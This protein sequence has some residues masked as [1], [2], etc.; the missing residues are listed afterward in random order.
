MS[1]PVN[2]NVYFVFSKLRNCVVSLPK[3]DYRESIS[4]ARRAVHHYNTPSVEQTVW[5]WMKED[6]VEK[7]YL[8]VTSKMAGRLPINIPMF[9]SLVCAEKELKRFHDTVVKMESGPEKDACEIMLA[10]IEKHAVS[11]GKLYKSAFDWKTQD[12]YTVYGCEGK[13]GQFKEIK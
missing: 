12:V 3:S 10:V 9:Y 2:I 5:D 8:N 13:D 11:L 4:N 6:G 7:S 1:I